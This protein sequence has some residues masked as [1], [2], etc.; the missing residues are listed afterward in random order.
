MSETRRRLRE[1]YATNG[2]QDQAKHCQ[3]PLRAFFPRGHSGEL[4]RRSVPRAECGNRRFYYCP[5]GTLPQRTRRV[6]V[7]AR[8]AFQTETSRTTC[9]EIWWAQGSME[10]PSCGVSRRGLAW[11]EGCAYTGGL[12][13]PGQSFRGPRLC[14]VAA[15]TVRS[16]RV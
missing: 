13:S 7:G 9:T 5:A 10:G 16:A 4:F 8:G 15:T 2:C 1:V 11:P 12:G 14:S 6:D 3:S